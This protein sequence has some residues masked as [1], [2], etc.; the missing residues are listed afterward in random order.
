MQGYKVPHKIQISNL[1]RKRLENNMTQSDL[2]AISGVPIK[3][4]GNYEQLRRDINH[5]RIDI[6]YALAD[7]L[8]CRM[9]DLME[10]SKLL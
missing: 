1:K 3:C 4:I 9:E 6:V 5:A 8:G 7:A 2:S 10:N